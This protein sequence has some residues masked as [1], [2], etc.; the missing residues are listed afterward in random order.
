M[1]KSN[2]LFLEQIKRT[3]SAFAYEHSGEMLSRKRKTQVLSGVSM[4]VVEQEK[5]PKVLNKTSS[6]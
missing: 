2:G 4:D 1:K 3:F 5:Y 6:F